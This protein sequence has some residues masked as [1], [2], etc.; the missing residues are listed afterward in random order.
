VKGTKKGMALA[1]RKIFGAHIFDKIIKTPDGSDNVS[2]DLYSLHDIMQCATDHA[3]RPD[4]DDV[5]ALIT[6]FYD[7]QF[8]FRETVNQN[9][10]KLKEEATKIKLFGLNIA[11]PKIVLVIVANINKAAKSGRWGTEFRTTTSK[12]KKLYPYNHKHDA[13]SMSNILAECAEADTARDVR[14][15]PA[16]GGKALAVNRS[17]LMDTL[18]QSERSN[19][20]DWSEFDRLNYNPE[21]YINSDGEAYETKRYKSE[22]R[23]DGRSVSSSIASSAAGKQQ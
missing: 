15:A 2:I 23:R 9:V 17:I 3:T 12:F 5:I 18:G 19:S 1:L 7:T 13:T 16:P 22:K 11:E 14:D 8:D 21:A 4:I 6:S 20:T 10:L